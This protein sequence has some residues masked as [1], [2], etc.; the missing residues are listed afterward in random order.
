MMTTT[1]SNKPVQL[2]EVNDFTAKNLQFDVEDE[3]S[4]GHGKEPMEN[5]AIVQLENSLPV[6]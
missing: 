3:E 4:K 6:T 1:I 5:G 2:L